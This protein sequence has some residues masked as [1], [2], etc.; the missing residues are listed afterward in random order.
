MAK[1]A[2]RAA[3]PFDTVRFQAIVG[4]RKR[5]LTHVTSKI[6]LHLPNVRTLNLHISK[7]TMSLFAILLYYVI[8]YY[9]LCDY[10]LLM[11]H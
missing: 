1:S 10:L 5:N 11:L 8:I 6:S 7:I 4:Y 3:G 9:V 2:R